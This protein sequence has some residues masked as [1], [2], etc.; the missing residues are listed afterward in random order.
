[1]L[2]SIRIIS[3]SQLNI[4]LCLHLKPINQVVYLDPY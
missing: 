3:T 2:V 4:L 1:M